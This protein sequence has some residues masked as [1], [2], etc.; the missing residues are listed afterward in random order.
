MGII[1]A[2]WAGQ[3]HARAM[4]AL[5]GRVE[6][7]TVADIDE[8]RARKLAADFKAPSWTTG[9]QDLLANEQI[10]AVSNCLPHHLHAPVTI[11][12]ANAGKHILVEKP[13]A[14]T[15]D[16]ADAMIAAADS[17]GVTLMVA[18]NVRFDATNQRVAQLVQEG[19]LGDI[20]LVRISRE[21]QMHDYLR[22]RPWFLSDPAG[23]I[24]YSGGIHDYELLR[25]VAGEIEHVYGLISPSTLPEMQADD[26]S[27]A[28][29]RLQNGASAVI[30]ESFSLKTP[31]TGVFGSI[32]GSAGSLWFHG[33]TI[34]LYTA[35]SDNQ[36]ELVQE[37]V[38]PQQDTF[39][40][41]MSHFLEAI[42]TPGMEPITSG[43]EERKPLAAVVATYRSFETGRRVYLE[44]LEAVRS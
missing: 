29:A 22:Q 20:F 5:P 1:G 43:R 12:A 21:H 4:A 15:L 41:E 32:H 6:L 33:D 30:V 36:P 19:R 11:E 8:A 18:E 39:I 31:E 34:R 9:Y 24:M 42:E 25:M 28:V 35:D 13:L 23:G 17:A 3:Q 44:S 16:E 10:D 7:L 14:T 2:G 37:E 26:N 40:A 38:V 27:V